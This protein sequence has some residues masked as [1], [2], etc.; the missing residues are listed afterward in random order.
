M[1]GLL[2]SDVV[3]CVRRPGR[4]PSVTLTRFEGADKAAEAR[5]LL[6]LHTEEFQPK[7]S[8]TRPANCR[9]VHLHRHS[10][11]RQQDAQREIVPALH[12]LVAFYLPPAPRDITHG[13]FARAVVA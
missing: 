13:P 10:L 7:F 5:L 1:V 4:N 2:N 9:E 6:W 11:I 8:S 12:R 3:M